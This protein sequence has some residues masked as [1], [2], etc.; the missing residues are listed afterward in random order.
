MTDSPF[1]AASP[2]RDLSS[3]ELARILVEH[4]GWLESNGVT[5]ER[6]MLDNARLAGVN[7]CGADLRRVSLVGAELSGARLDSADLSSGSLVGADFTGASLRAA[8]L[9]GADL[10]ETILRNAD[11]RDADLLES[12]G[13][14]GGRLGGADV[15]GAKLPDAIMKFEGLES[16]QESSKSASS[17]FTSTLLLCAYTWLTILAT[18]DA[19]LLNN[20]APP[21]SRLPILGTDIPLI[22]FYLVGP[23]LLFCFYIYFHLCLQRLWEELANLPAVFPDAR[24]LDSKAHPWMLNSLVCLHVDRLRRARPGLTLWQARLAALVAWGI[25]P[26]TLILIWA[27]Y[28]TSHHWWVTGAH[29]ILIAVSIGAGMG[30]YHLAIETLRGSKRVPFRVTRPLKDVRLL[31]GIL[32][33]ITGGL[34]YMVSL[35]AIDGVNNRLVLKEISV[36]LVKRSGFDPRVWIPEIL[37]QVGVRSFAALDGI[38]L[39]TK[40]ANW[41]GKETDLSLVKGA[42]LAGRDLRFADAYGAFFVN[43]FLKG[44]DLRGAD[45]READFRNADLRRADLSGANLRGAKL[46][47]ADLHGAKLPLAVLTEADLTSADL[48]GVDLSHARL[49][50]ADLTGADL[51]DANLQGADLTGAK[52]VKA[53]LVSV[54]MR[55]ANLQGADL[56]GAKLAVPIK[57]SGK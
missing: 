10:D 50:G 39:S 8:N 3:Q 19:Q 34:F 57:T 17:L 51:T 21:A 47:G 31:Y 38:D 30:F 28:L 11:L 15:A 18:R 54:K 6:A 22:Q 37:S 44:A 20:A 42:D 45:L 1:D 41:S 7:L 33:I 46:R 14:S 9:R 13:L 27:R 26:F 32:T 24:S 23:L 29:V 40:P 4:R 49:H 43:A 16:V 35:G 56:T 53:T 55:D 52:L 25:V 2:V 5:G 36:D 12:R 48:G